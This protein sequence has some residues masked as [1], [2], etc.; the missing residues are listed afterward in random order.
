MP[1]AFQP[2]APTTGTLFMTLPTLSHLF[3]SFPTISGC[4]Y[5]PESA[6]SRF[7]SYS[8]LT[9]APTLAF[10]TIGS[11]F[12]LDT[13][14]SN[15]Y[16][17]IQPEEEEVIAFQIKLLSKRERNNCT[18]YK[19]L[20]AVIEAVKIHHHYLCGGQFLI[21][22]DHQAT[23]RLHKF[24]NL[25]DQLARWLE[26]LRAQDFNIDHWSGVEHW[27]GNTLSK[28]P[29]SNCQFCD[30]VDKK[31]TMPQLRFL[32]VQTS[33]NVAHLKIQARPHREIIGP[34]P[35]PI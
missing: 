17:Q 22:N 20:L 26:L 8:V 16:K 32:I 35:S 7:V 3:T 6:K 9:T 14:A 4:S 21:R 10:P 18:T 27:N 33:P 2:L 1:K 25:D 24:R 5:G 29:C 34:L 15:K 30:H 23:K 11:L 19:E 31:T 12:I 28:R 13:D